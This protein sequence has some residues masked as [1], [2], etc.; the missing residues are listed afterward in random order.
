M[1]YQTIRILTEYVRGNKDVIPDNGIVD[2]GVQIVRQ[3]NVEE[4]KAELEQLLGP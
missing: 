3:E 1:G 2:T 4:F